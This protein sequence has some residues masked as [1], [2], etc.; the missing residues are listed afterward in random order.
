MSG[1]AG[2]WRAAVDGHLRRPSGT[3]TLSCGVEGGVFVWCGLAVWLGL[4]GAIHRAIWSG[5]A[6]QWFPEG[7]RLLFS[8]SGLHLYAMR[9]DFQIGPLSFVAVTPLIFG[10]PA[11]AAEATAMVLMSVAGLGVL[12]GLRTLLPAP[13]RRYDVRFVLAAVCFLTVWAELA[14]TFTHAD[15]VLAIGFTIAALHA[16]HAERTYRAAALLAIAADCKPWA[17]AFVVL[18]LLAGSGRL[19]A[20]AVWTAGVLVVWLPFVLADP[21]TLSAAQ[22]RIPNNAASSLRTLGVHAWGTPTW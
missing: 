15:D 10:L 18:L 8:G 3:A 21:G 9:P 13:W 12:A 11:G 17:A 6:W 5:Q 16:V 2:G 14:V 4:L 20:L 19:R 1:G 7:A 22:Y